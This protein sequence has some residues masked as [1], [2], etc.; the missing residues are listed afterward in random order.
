MK[1]KHM[2][3]YHP[4]TKCGPISIIVVVSSERGTCKGVPSALFT[5]SKLISVE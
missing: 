1:L 5:G 3:A 2:Y 4:P